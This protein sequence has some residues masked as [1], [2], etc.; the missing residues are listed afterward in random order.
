MDAEYRIDCAKKVFDEEIRALT[1]IRNRLDNTFSSI[2]EKI[3]SCKGKVVLCGMGKSGHIARKVSA[4]LSSLGISSFFLH[5][6]EAVHGDLGMVSDTDIVILISHS[7]ETR[8]ILQ[9]LS[10]LKVIGAELIAITGNKD[11][12]LAK[13]CNLCQILEIEKEACFLNLAPTSSTTSVLVYGDAL[14]VVAS[15]ETGFGKSDF[16]LF[17]PAGTLGKKVL[18]KVNDI[19]VTGENIPLV[20]CGIKITDAIMEMSK[21][22]LG[23]VAVTEQTGKLAGILT[24]GDLRRAIEKRSDLYG[25]IIDSIMTKNPKYIYADILLVDALQKL[26][27]SRLNNYPVVDGENNV[28]G[29]LTWQMIVREGIVL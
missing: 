12:T 7:G 23:V 11:S 13:E 5:P 1:A 25:D 3:I 24:D 22:G 4:T 2:E 26:K 18:T 14:A 16:G 28:I 8:E 21:K 15:L 29:M 20:K 19:M 6:A 27:E 9:L 17:H 10:S